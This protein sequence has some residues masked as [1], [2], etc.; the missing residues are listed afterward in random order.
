MQSGRCIPAPIG[1]SLL[2]AKAALQH[3]LTT[4][5]A[6]SFDRGA[7]LSLDDFERFVFVLTVLE[8][9]SDWDC[10]FLLSCFIDDF[11]NARMRALL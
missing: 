11:W 9:Y 10:A 4:A 8:Q 6:E 1:Q 3:N 7:V 2:P 5:K